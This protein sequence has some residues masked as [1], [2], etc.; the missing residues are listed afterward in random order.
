MISITQVIEFHPR[1][2]ASSPYLETLPLQKQVSQ[3]NVQPCK[4]PYGF[5]SWKRVS[6]RAG[7]QTRISYARATTL[8]IAAWLAA[9]TT[10]RVVVGLGMTVC[11]W[12]TQVTACTPLALLFLMCWHQQSQYACVYLPQESLPT[13]VNSLPE[14]GLE[15]SVDIPVENYTKSTK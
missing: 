1:T 4:Q 7:R 3:T 9:L 10:H 15:C 5:S 2:P 8:N 6:P 13:R 11:G 12:L 14:P